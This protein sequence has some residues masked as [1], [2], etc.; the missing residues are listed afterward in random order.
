M[1]VTFHY[2]AR[3]G[4]SYLPPTMMH[5]YGAKRYNHPLVG[6]VTVWHEATQ[7]AEVATQ[8]E[9]ERSNLLLA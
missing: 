1:A 2:R 9:Q 8:A 3:D 7:L 4:A 5:R 6:D